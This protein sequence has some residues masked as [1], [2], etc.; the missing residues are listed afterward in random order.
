MAELAF[1]GPLA[2]YM[3]VEQGQQQQQLTREQI[4]NTQAL[5][6]YHDVSARS[7]EQEMMLKAR[8][9][10]ESTQRLQLAQSMWGKA[11]QDTK[12]VPGNSTA[13]TPG[14]SP[15]Q[16]ERLGGMLEQQMAYINNL[17]GAGMITEAQ[18]GMK[19]LM[20][21]ADKLSVIR[22]N[23]TEQT[24]KGY[25]GG[26]KVAAQINGAVAG[27]KDQATFDMAK[28][29]LMSTLPG[30]PIPPW[31]N[32]PYDQ[33]KPMIEKLQTST[34]EGM[35]LAKI[36][37]EIQRNRASAGEQ[38]ALR[39][40]NELR[41]KLEQ[42]EVT[43][44][45]ERTAAAVKAG[46]PKPSVLH[47]DKGSG[48]VK[49]SAAE[50]TNADQMIRAGNELFTGFDEILK[51][52][53][54]SS[55]GT[56][57]DLAYANDPTF[58]GGAKKWLA[59]KMTSDE[60]QKYATRLAGVNV[61]AAIIASGGRAPRVSQME[62]EKAAIAELSGQSRQVFF[63]KIHQATLK[64]IRGVEITRPGDEQQKNNLELV[65]TRLKRIEEDT[66]AA[67]KKGKSGR[68][69]SGAVA[70]PNITQEAYGKLQKGDKFWWNGEEHT[71]E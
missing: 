67:L 21:N 3:A 62:A 42:M 41:A 10:Q 54:G 52:P 37:S 65:M 44:A 70:Q 2:G 51:L 23:E 64:A 6:R 34:K 36:K 13:S 8:Q 19:D 50:R 56:F 69:S 68:T 43:A 35:E 29:Q 55:M 18:A 12:P 66:A 11:M 38:D 16:S 48:V 33:A 46:E 9:A 47:P 61:A 49:I 58:I 24:V 32:L 20:A 30:M 15:S 27:V 25:E 5:A 17:A 26:A 60:A 63:D 40:L 53:A 71:K 59:N 45:E 31:F 39:R 22:K 7:A 14:A 57:S 1:E 4:L 28:M